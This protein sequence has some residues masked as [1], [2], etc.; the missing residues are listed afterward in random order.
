MLHNVT[1]PVNENIS[2]LRPFTPQLHYVT[3][4]V[5]LCQTAVLLEAMCIGVLMPSLP[6]VSPC[7][8]LAGSPLDS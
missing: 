5:G 8:G 3:I 1:D 6:F 7:E 4:I 2:V